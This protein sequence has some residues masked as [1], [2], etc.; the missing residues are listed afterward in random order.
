MDN[1]I[2]DIQPQEDSIKERS[3]GKKIFKRILKVIKIIIYILLSI[4]LLY[5]LLNF[6][7]SLYE[8]SQ[9]SSYNYG[10][11]IDVNGHKMNVVIDGE[12]NNQTIVFL[13]GYIVPSPYLHYKPFTK[14]LSKDYKIITLEPFG[15]GLSDTVDEERTVDNVVSELHSAIKTLK[16]D[17]YY[18]MGHSLGGSYTYYWATKYP[19]EV[20]GHIG[21]DITTPLEPVEGTDKFVEQ[22]ITRNNLGYQRMTSLFN[23]DNLIVPLP[24]FPNGYTDE[25]KKMYRV[26]T[27]QKGYNKNIV[28]EAVHMA[29]NIKVTYEKKLPKDIKVLSF[30]STEFA[31]GLPGFKDALL[32]YGNQSKVNEVVELKGGHVSVFIEEKETILKKVNSFIA[33]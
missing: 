33:L 1:K 7:L 22:I 31:L 14:D 10:E 11:K 28:S 2:I 25:E 3:K 32:E 12:K 5:V 29:E 26:I 17:K 13:N 8:K 21:F 16:I 4:I 23:E 30:M 24:A 19:T 6:S 18:L 20:L 27:L 15:Y 9:L